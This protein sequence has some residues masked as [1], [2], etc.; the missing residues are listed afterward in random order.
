MGSSKK[1]RIS[2]KIL[3]LL[4]LSLIGSL[5]V[6]RADESESLEKD[7]FGSVILVIGAA[8]EEQ[9]DD[10]F[11]AWS[12]Q[13]ETGAIGGGKA[14]YLV[15]PN[16][17]DSETSVLSELEEIINKQDR[18]SLHE[19]WVIFLGHG[20]YDGRKGK[21][22]LVGPDLAADQLKDWL[23]DFE[24]PLVLSFCFSASAPF[25]AELARPGVTIVSATKSGNE[26]NFS[27][28]G[29][30]FAASIGDLSADLDKDGQVSVLEAFLMGS[31]RLEEYYLEEGLLATEHPIL[32]DNGDG[33]GVGA[34][35][36][37][38]VRPEKQATD[39]SLVDGARAKQIHLMATSLEQ[40]MPVAMRVKR[41]ELEIA[42]EKLYGRKAGM[43]KS[44]YLKALERLLVEIA[45]L[46]KKADALANQGTQED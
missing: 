4:L 30:Y 45:E 17:L 34:D 7:D 40:R 10:L 3:G 32:D 28:F 21:F 44:D 42:I 39:G 12:R 20:Q 43:E 15:G 18:K 33:K 16:S 19:L 2:L 13:W 1:E 25:L 24:R 11:E 27:R 26:N 31:R 38:G 36:F 22:N 14:L 29:R 41:D 46:Y 23:S 5:A 9:Y 6:V 37:K 8:G 35:W